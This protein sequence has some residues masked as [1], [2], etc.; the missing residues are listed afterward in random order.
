MTDNTGTE[1]VSARYIGL[2]MRQGHPDKPLALLDFVDQS[3]ATLRVTIPA[4]QLPRLQ[5]DIQRKSAQ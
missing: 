5:S 4:D 3:G 2:T 1:F